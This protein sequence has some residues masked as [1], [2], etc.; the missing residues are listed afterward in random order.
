MP[1]TTSAVA[2]ANRIQGIGNDYTPSES[3][4]QSSTGF[5]NNF[6]SNIS[7]TIY[8]DGTNDIAYAGHPGANG[9]FVDSGKYSN[10]NPNNNTYSGPDGSSSSSA[11]MVGIGNPN[12]KDPR[13]QE[14]GWLQKASEYAGMSSVGSKPKPVENVN[15]DS[16]YQFATNRGSGAYGINQEAYS[17]HVV[18]GFGNQ[19]PSSNWGSVVPDIPQGPIG[20]GRA[21][22]AASDGAYE[23]SLIESLCEPGGLKPIPS[24]AKLKDFLIAATTLSPDLVGECLIEVL[25]SDNWQSKVKALIVI[26]HLVVARDCAGHLEWWISNLEEIKAL[27][28][29][30][31]ASVRVQANKTLKVVVGD[32]DDISPAGSVTPPPSNGN[33]NNLLDF[34]DS[35]PP[36]VTSYSVPT[37]V[38]VATLPN[39]TDM[40]AGLS[41]NSSVSSAQ[42]PLQP[43]APITSSFDFLSATTPTNNNLPVS[44]QTYLPTQGNFPPS[45]SPK[46]SADFSIFDDLT[47]LKPSISS[48]EPPLGV[49][50]ESSGFNFLGASTTLNS[51]NSAQLISSAFSEPIQEKSTSSAFQE[52]RK[53]IF[54]I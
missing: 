46:P 25:N 33:N 9:S 37:V 2:A 18:N 31:K 35:N 42:V 50:Q 19:P 51:G 27:T 11:G 30:S 23:K 52:V 29:D 15:P 14:K 40:F 28:S 3:T 10:S 8:G 39:T 53:T 34:I 26:S 47:V 22:H 36:P 5:L 20:S 48:S 44:N 1:T 16:D 54:I 49:T 13:N 4:K 17:P 12:F 43:A 6:V 41:L 21:G 32:S 38:P 45:T 24:E 7:S